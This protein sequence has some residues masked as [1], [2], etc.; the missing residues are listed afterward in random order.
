MDSLNKQMQDIRNRLEKDVSKAFRTAV[1]QTCSQ[2]ITGSPV[3]TGRL[4]GNWQVTLNSV[5][6]SYTDNKE[7]LIGEAA[8]TISK[9]TFNDVAYITNNLPYA[10][11]IEF[12]QYKGQ[13]RQGNVRNAL[14][15]F[16]AKLTVALQRYQAGG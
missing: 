16:D 2:I 10:E 9:F 13:H 3:I 8:S 12:G 1:I 7:A 6:S 4:R 14:N 15:E 5:P 11:F